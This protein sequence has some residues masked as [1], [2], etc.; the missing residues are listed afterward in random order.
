MLL[1]VGSLAVMGAALGTVLGVAAR[2]F[3]VESDPLE[4]DLLDLLPGSQ[5][6]QCGYVGCGQAAAA[7]AKGE[8]AVTI[9]IPGG[10]AVAEKLAHRLGVAAD[11]SGHKD[12]E[13]H[14]AVINE[15]LC[16]GCLRCANECSTDAIIGAPKQIHTVLVDNCHGCAKC[17]NTCPTMAVTMHKINVN[18]HDWHWHKPKLK[19]KRIKH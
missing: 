7:L 11:L 15:D 9:C 12:A 8:A 5:C 10:K 16:I 4:A 14:Y 17:F 1:A 6:G 3:A 2:Y 19:A 18:L 13:P